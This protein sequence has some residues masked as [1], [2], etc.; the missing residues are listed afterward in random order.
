MASPSPDPCGLVVKNGSKTRSATSWRDARAVVG[1]LDLDGIA[2]VGAVL[3]ADAH[4][5]DTVIR[6]VPFMAS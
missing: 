3:E 5:R 6:P 1:D 4:R 2:P